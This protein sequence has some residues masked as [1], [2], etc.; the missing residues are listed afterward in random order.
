MDFSPF[1]RLLICRWHP[2]S[3]ALKCAAVGTLCILSNRPWNRASWSDPSVPIFVFAVV[4]VCVCV[5]T[6]CAS[7]FNSWY[8]MIVWLEHW[9]TCFCVSRSDRLIR[10]RNIQVGQMIPGYEWV[11]DWKLEAASAY[12]F[13]GVAMIKAL[14]GRSVHEC[15]LSIINLMLMA[16]IGLLCLFLGCCHSAEP[17]ADWWHTMLR[18]VS[19][20]NPTTVASSDFGQMAMD[21]PVDSSYN[22]LL[23]DRKMP[24]ILLPWG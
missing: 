11:V 1:V 8:A 21:F 6:E 20:A 23:Y 24:K 10:A 15:Q 13:R 9:E 3:R 7:C 18:G 16:S 2:D 22:T 19:K 14:V 4:C 17:A 5:C 12:F